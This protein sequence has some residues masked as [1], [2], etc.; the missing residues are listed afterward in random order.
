MTRSLGTGGKGPLVSLRGII[1]TANRAQIVRRSRHG[2]RQPSGARHRS[3]DV[4]E[5]E[6][7]VARH[8]AGGRR[9]LQGPSGHT[10]PDRA[11][12]PLQPQRTTQN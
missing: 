4:I 6:L 1:N 3:G 5:H 8:A 9:R 2:C 11:T 12:P 10:P 7:I